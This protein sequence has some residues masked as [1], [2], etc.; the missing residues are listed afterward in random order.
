M[1]VRF[2][3]F[4]LHYH[5]IITYFKQ[6]FQYFIKFFYEILNKFFLMPCGAYRYGI[7]GD[8][9]HAAVIDFCAAM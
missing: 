1:V 5:Y 9:K 6:N 8:G 7:C 4:L 2:Q 3:N